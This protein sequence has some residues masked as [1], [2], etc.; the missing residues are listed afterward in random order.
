MM[1]RV[2]SPPM[3]KSPSINTNTHTGPSFS[4]QSRIAR[5]TWGLVESTV[6]RMS[7][8]PLHSW[9]SFL[10]RCF[11]AK[12]G[13]RS[14]IYPGVRVWAPWNLRI[15]N[16]CGIGDGTTLYSQ[17]LISLGNR[18]VISQECYI[19]TGTHDYEC[20]GFP[21]RTAPIDIGDHAWIAAQ[22]FIHPG[23]KIGNGAVIGAR[24]V[25]TTDVPDWTVCSGFPCHPIKKRT[26]PR[27]GDPYPAKNGNE[28]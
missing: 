27:S 23:V 7:P 15:G 10:L 1:V 25:V 11:G 3:V 21:L 6:F 26:P 24:S 2:E 5:F 14:H 8:R 9:R 22:A 28:R 4:L 17:G 19:C 13:T 16:E 12:I 20:E 18:V